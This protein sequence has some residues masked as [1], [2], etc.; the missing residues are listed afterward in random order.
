[1]NGG[2]GIGLPPCVVIVV[3][4]V[5]FDVIVIYVVEVAVDVF[6]CCGGIGHCLCLLDSI[7]IFAGHRHGFGLNERPP[8]LIL[9]VHFCPSHAQISLT[10]PAHSHRALNINI[11]P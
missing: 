8:I 1:M 6:V 7:Y 11:C 2:Y 9:L 5:D 10:P 3:V 4:V